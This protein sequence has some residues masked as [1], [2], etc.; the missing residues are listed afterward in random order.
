MC[1][2][3]CVVKS[4]EILPGS[5]KRCGSAPNSDLRKGLASW[6]PLRAKRP[7]ILVRMR[8]ATRAQP[9]MHAREGAV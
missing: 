1:T 4:C 5:A 8:D 6:H 3:S 2:P 7:S 9:G